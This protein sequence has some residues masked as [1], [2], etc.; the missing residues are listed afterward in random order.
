MA[1]E[2]GDN[3]I[4]LNEASNT[5]DII[6]D[7]Y[8]FIINME[9]EDVDISKEMMKKQSMLLL[10][11]FSP[12]EKLHF[13]QRYLFY[14][15]HLYI[16]YRASDAGQ[17]EYS[18]RGISHHGE[19]IKYLLKSL[20]AIR[21]Q[22]VQSIVRI[23]TAKRNAEI[24]EKLKKRSLTDEELVVC[25]PIFKDL[26]KLFYLDKR[27]N[28]DYFG[29]ELIR[30]FSRLFSCVLGFLAVVYSLL[31][32][33][34]M[35]LYEG[36]TVFAVMN[37]FGL[38]VFNRSY[39]RAFYPR[40]STPELKNKLEEFFA[41]FRKMNR[42]QLTEF[43]EKQL[44]DP[45]HKNFFFLIPELLLKVHE[46]SPSKTDKLVTKADVYFAVNHLKNLSDARFNE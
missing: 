20:S 28:I 23:K 12:S 33:E 4:C 29:M 26:L 39:F 44:S 31:D 13:K 30:N 5:I 42:S 16:E 1:V 27:F 14:D 18:E 17:K 34:Y 10:G 37:L 25:T 32:T 2:I 3:L 43:G 38:L 6:R 40:R 15:T 9:L 7:F 35:G 46:Y 19:S 11:D 36:I 45:D 41:F 24:R 21:N 8:S 22:V